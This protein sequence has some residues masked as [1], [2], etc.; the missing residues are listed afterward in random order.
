MKNIDVKA[1][2]YIYD[3]FARENGYEEAPPSIDEF[4]E[5]EFYLGDITDNG[6]SIYPYWRIFLRD[7]YPTPFF[8]YDNDLKL[9]I[10]AGATGIG[11]CLASEQLVDVMMND[12]DIEEYDLTDYIIDSMIR[13]P[14][15]VLYSKLNIKHIPNKRN[16]IIGQEHEAPCEIFIKTPEGKLTLLNKLVTKRSDVYEYRLNNS[17]L[18][19]SDK[20]IVIENGK[21]I[22]IKDATSIDNIDGG[23]HKIISSKIIRRDDVVYDF[24]IDNP[25][26]YCTPD[27]YIHHNTTVAQYIFLYDLTRVLCMAKPQQ[28]FKLPGNTIILFALTN[29]T[30]DAAEAINLDPIMGMMRKSPF[31][32]SKFSKDKKD[33]TLFKNN[34]NLFI[35]SSKRQLVGKTIY[36]AISDEI[37]QEV[38]RGGSS[39]LV[40]EMINRINS[41]FLMKGNKWPG[42]Y[43]L[44]SST[45]S[46]D[47][48][49]EKVQENFKDNPESIKLVSPARYEVK[50]H[51]DIYSGKKFKIFVGNYSSDPFIIKSDDDLIRANEIDVDKVIDVPIEHFMEFKQNIYSGIQD[52]LGM[53]TVDSS[54]FIKDKTKIK[55]ALNLTP[56]IDK[57]LYVIPHDEETAIID[58]FNKERLVALGLD[59]PRAIGIDIG[60]NEDR[61]GFTMLHRR[62]D[63]KIERELQGRDGT[64]E[65]FVYWADLCFAMLPEEGK[66]LQLWKIRDFIRDLN[67]LGFPIKIVTSD[68]YQSVDTLQLLEKDGF[69]VKQ[70]SVD[71]TK[72]AYYKL[73]SAI[74]EEK[75]KCAYND[76]LFEEL[77]A[78]VEGDKKIDHPCRKSAIHEL[79]Q[80]ELNI[81]K[82]VS[83]S[84][85]GALYVFKDIPIH[86]LENLIPLQR[87]KERAGT[88]VGNAQMDILLDNR[89]IQVENIQEFNQS[90]I[91]NF[92]M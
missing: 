17:S 89:D 22:L 41:R 10:L 84:L 8:E 81:S 58:F 67:E 31:F 44:I 9:E 87:L 14:I 40:A 64:I 51:L 34:I 70:Y 59:H 65:D 2:K 35:A 86:E 47:S 73:R 11:K 76:I 7:M 29:A 77:V 19:A 82:D 32:V 62:F 18:K 69:V 20:H 24:S 48:I 75:I 80:R 33:K 38:Q 57:N 90:N 49:M 53:V 85:A 36:S 61:F 88:S 39:L 15:G 21:D 55:K 42:N 68:S 6:K 50:S 4:I 63:P 12:K 28:K 13:I 72:N 83:D 52:V 26:L 66:K 60:L 1:E 25:H 92:K 23:V 71:K 45:T 43:V 56:L 30:L 78:L 74:D 3:K 16:N 91:N 5:D 54:T 37:N 79:K 46:D 27:G